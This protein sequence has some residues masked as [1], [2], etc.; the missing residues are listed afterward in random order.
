MKR[1]KNKRPLL[2]RL[3]LHGKWRVWRK[4]HGPVAAYFL[5]FRVKNQTAELRIE[6]CKKCGTV[7]GVMD[8]NY[9]QEITDPYLLGKYMNHIGI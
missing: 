2:C 8:N 3:G 4:G 9:A 1:N 7:R 6:S 5:G